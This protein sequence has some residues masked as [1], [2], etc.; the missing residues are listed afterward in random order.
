MI[1]STRANSRRLCDGGSSQS[2]GVVQPLVGIAAGKLET[3]VQDQSLGGVGNDQAGLLTA[4]DLSGAGTV[5]ELHVANRAGALD[6]EVGGELASRRDLDVDL[7]AGGRQGHDVGTHVAGGASGLDLIAVARLVDV[8]KVDAALGLVEDLLGLVVADVDVG[9]V[10]PVLADNLAGG[11]VAGH[12]VKG[13]EGRLVAVRLVLDH[14]LVKGVLAEAGNVV[15][16]VGEVGQE[17]PGLVVVTRVDGAVDNN[18]EGV[19]KYLVDL[20]LGAA[21]GGLV[22]GA[23]VGAE[24]GGVVGVGNPVGDRLPP[25]AGALLVDPG[26]LVVVQ[27]V[28]VLVNGDARGGEVGVDDLE[29]AGAGL[30]L[31]VH[32]AGGVVKL[33]DGVDVGLVVRAVV[34]AFVEGQARGP[35]AKGVDEAL[36]GTLEHGEGVIGGA[37]AGVDAEVG[38]VLEVAAAGAGLGLGLELGGLSA[39]DYL[40]GACLRGRMDAGGE[41]EEDCEE[42]LV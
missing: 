38:R 1:H 2:E 9:H 29:P 39:R 31:R 40:G 22:L 37:A 33:G 30:V 35:P 21:L 32:H 5:G 11:G 24:G 41:G 7:A 34:G 6:G 14:H 25:G 18:L 12:A 36:V 4:G 3:V 20:E 8:G 17:R 23:G 19:A 27:G 16:V 28:A 10:G 42:K 26:A 13:V 15:R